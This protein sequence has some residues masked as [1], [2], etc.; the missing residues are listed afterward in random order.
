MKKQEENSLDKLFSSLHETGNEIPSAAFLQDLEQRL[1]AQKK[2]RKPLVF[3]WIFSAFGAILLS[4]VAFNWKNSDAPKQ[5]LSTI[6]PSSSRTSNNSLSTASP[7]SSTSNSN[8]NSTSTSTS[9]SSIASASSKAIS[10]NSSLTSHLKEAQSSFISETYSISASNQAFSSPVLPLAKANSNSNDL[11]VVFSLQEEN[12]NDTSNTIQTKEEEI[13][14]ITSRDIVNSPQTIVKSSKHTIGLQFGV[15]GIFSS[16]EVPSQYASFTGYDA[17]KFRSERELS[18]RQTS[19]WDFNLRYQYQLGKLGLQTGFNYL[20]W[21]E[22]YKY[23][24]ISVEGINRYQYVQIP[25]GVSYQIPVKKVIL[26]PAIG[27]AIGYGIQTSGNYI[28]PSSNGVALVKAKQFSGNLW[29]QLE[30]VYQLN[31]QICVSVAPVY[32]RTLGNLVDNGLIINRYQSF[33]LLTGLS[34]RF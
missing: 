13:T 14:P 27:Y 28:L 30:M 31:E 21:G 1:D 8:S 26:Q 23:A 11:N 4:V 29:A 12:T 20:E 3:W 25:I 24:V 32:R 6:K 33:G 7:H 9:T 34:Y 22:Q 5:A 16:F 17:F 2:R 18:E 19:S 15:S 10:F